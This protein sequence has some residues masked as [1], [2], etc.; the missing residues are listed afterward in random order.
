M[1]RLRSHRATQFVSALGSGRRHTASRLPPVDAEAERKE[2][3]V[4]LTP[5]DETAALPADA[6]PPDA[7]SAIERRI[8]ERLAELQ[9]MDVDSI[10]ITVQDGQVILAGVIRGYTDG[11]VA[12]EV[13]RA[14]PGVK[15]VRSHLRLAPVRLPREVVPGMRVVS[16]RHDELG[17]VVESYGDS[18]LMHDGAGRS[19]YVPF[20][21]I[22]GVSPSVVTIDEPTWLAEQP[23]PPEELRR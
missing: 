20:F 2:A 9:I 5:P 4:S 13:A 21:A 12:R 7:D 11:L 22:H 3:R 16:V 23:D 17:N 6:S 14:V 19:A 18:F 10:T 15:V 8:R 1:T